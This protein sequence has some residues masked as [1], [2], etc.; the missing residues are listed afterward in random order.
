MKHSELISTITKETGKTPKQKELAEIINKPV[1]TISARASR[2]LKYSFDEVEKIE[3]YYG[4]DFANQ[5]FID[6]IHDSKG[7]IPADFYPESYVSCGNGTFE[8]S[9]IKE[10]IRIPKMSFSEYYSFAKYSVIKAYGD[11]MN[12]QIQD[13]D[14]LI[15]KHCNSGD[16]IKDN[17]V[18]VFCYNDKIFVKRLILSL[19]RITVISD[20]P[21]K[22]LYPTQFIEKEEMNNVH[23]VGQIVGLMRNKV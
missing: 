2:D 15:V 12:P 11:S 4:I 13:K 20:N 19:N 22:E 9:P 18:Y 3:K 1:N 7:E 23:L 8:F 16:Q 6:D 21:D 5:P 17:Q 10:K 14:L